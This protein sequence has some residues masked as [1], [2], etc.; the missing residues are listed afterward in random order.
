M[1][2]IRPLPLPRTVPA[3]VAVWRLDLDLQAPLH[4]SD[5]ALLSED[6]RNRAWRFHRHAD[7]VRAV[8]TRSALRQLLARRTGRRA[9]ELRFAANAHGKPEL[10]SGTG[11]EFN[12]SHAGSHA[13]IAFSSGR[14]IGVD[15]ECHAGA[16]EVQELGAH[17]F[18]RRERLAALRPG[19]AIDDFM[20]RWTAK[21]A[22]LKALGQG[23]AEY[24]QA[25]S[26]LPR[27]EAGEGYQVLHDRP[28]WGEIA[29]WPLD[30]PAGYSAALALQQEH[31]WAVSCP[32]SV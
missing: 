7:R 15:I 1:N 3:D 29:V 27:S 20:A 21:E 14:P 9:G 19:T 31:P 13:M 23:I 2:E 12:V 28:E 5:L 22:T 11:I 18:T 17:V 16:A 32:C 25:I 8:A 26:I 10:D 4:P 24:L 30:A 6:E